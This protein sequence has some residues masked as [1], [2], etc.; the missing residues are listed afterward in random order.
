M[1]RQACFRV[2]QPEIAIRAKAG[3]HLSTPVPLRYGT[4]L[5]GA[6]IYQIID[7]LQADLDAWI[8]AYNHKASDKLEVA[9]A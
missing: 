5:E 6:R 7:E 4:A 9:G 8:A 3:I 1:A 2:P